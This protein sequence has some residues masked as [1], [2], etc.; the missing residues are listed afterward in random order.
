MKKLLLALVALSASAALAATPT[1][2]QIDNIQNSTG[3]SS[4]AV[5]GTGTTLITDTNTVTLTNKS[6]SGSTNTFSNI[7]TSSLA[8]GF[9]LSVGQGGTGDTTFTSNG[10]LYGNGTS[11]L[12]VT[13]AG[14]QYQVLQA[15]SGG[16]PQFGA[17][18]LAQSAAVTGALGA[19]NGGSGTASPTAHGVL[20]GEGSSAFNSISGSSAGQVLTWNSSGDPS[21]QAVSGSAPTI[22]GTA[23]SPLSVTAS[24]GVSLTTP[25]Y[26]NVAFIKGSSAGNTTV[27]ATPSITACTAAGQTL[28]IVSESSTNTVTLQNNADLSGSQVL[29]NGPWT[30]GEN[31]STPYVLYLV[32][33]GA[34]TPNWVETSRSN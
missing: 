12:A 2:K 5:P 3:G 13:A 6:I 14:T 23:A 32:C 22:N 18:N 31:N 16:T 8:S 9:T 27:T 15:G 1:D 30:S 4:L 28:E 7:P 24:G 17:L 25:T 21:F 10:I 34:G 29:L 20:V 26:V 33:D 11:A 19:A